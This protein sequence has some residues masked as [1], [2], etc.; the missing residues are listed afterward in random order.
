ML[1]LAS[2]DHHREGLSVQ[3]CHVV[4]YFCLFVHRYDY[5]DYCMD[6]SKFPKP[7]FVSEF[8]FQSYPSSTSMKSVS[9]YE[10]RGMQVRQDFPS[11]G[12]WVLGE[13]YC[14]F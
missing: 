8:G 2:Q 1:L 5:N 12:V 7:R 13:D 11:V 4:C 3:H 6:V 9:G 14:L 10:V